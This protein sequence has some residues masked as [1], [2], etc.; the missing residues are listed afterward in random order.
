MFTEKPLAQ[1][2]WFSSP[3][4][5]FTLSVL[6]SCAVDPGGVASNIWTG[7]V[8]SRPPLRCSAC[9]QGSARPAQRQQRLS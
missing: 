6:Q 7:S 8:F 3:L 5:V 4:F 9:P 1:Q 2:V